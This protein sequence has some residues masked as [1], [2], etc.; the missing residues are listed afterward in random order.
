MEDFLNE[1][2]AAVA[3]KVKELLKSEEKKTDK[4]EEVL[5]TLE[6]VC[7]K[8]KIS[9]TTLYRYRKSGYIIPSF[10]S[11]HS[12]RFTEKDIDD[13]FQRFKN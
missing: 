7:K 12:A 10:Y 3:F 2:A 11:G 4:K 8:L 13:Y 6:E 1:I 9:R 5:Y